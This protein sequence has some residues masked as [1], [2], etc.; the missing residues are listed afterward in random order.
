MEPLQGIALSA[1]LSISFTISLITTWRCD[2]K[3]NSHRKVLPIGTLW[4][5]STLIYITIPCITKNLFNISTF[6]HHETIHILTRTHETQAISLSIMAFSAGYYLLHKLAGQ[7]QHNTSRYNQRGDTL[8]LKSNY[9]AKGSL[10]NIAYTSGLIAISV[11]ILKILAGVQSRF[12]HSSLQINMLRIIDFIPLGILS[13]SIY[14][15]TATS[16]IATAGD[17]N[18]RSA[19]QIA[20]LGFLILI[21]EIKSGSRS[22]LL[23]NMLSAVLGLAYSGQW[24][25]KSTIKL[26]AISIATI[27]ILVPSAE[28]LRI[29]R[30][31]TDFFKDN[32][33]RTIERIKTGA[34]ETLQS[35]PANWV[36]HNRRD[37]LS[38]VV[39]PT[40]SDC[41]NAMVENKFSTLPQA[42][43]LPETRLADCIQHDEQM[44]K[45]KYLP[46]P[47]EIAKGIITG[48][49]KIL[50]DPDERMNKLANKASA[51]PGSVSKGEKLTLIADSY[52][53]FGYMGIAG[54]FVTLGFIYGTIK[55]ILIKWSSDGLMEKRIT[56]AL[57]PI[58]LMA[59]TFSY[60]LLT[61]GWAAL[62]FL[63]KLIISCLLIAFMAKN[64]TH[65]QT[66]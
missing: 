48:N 3:L 24:K 59:G 39:F 64:R 18:R 26:I 22:Y 23:S 43:L 51:R 65:R 53:R 1:V 20:I 35:N 9:R 19:M 49:T 32:P 36:V 63:P 50:F 56:I 58:V 62:V 34:L 27:A 54:V 5:I 28:A 55:K 21:L 40:S 16:L 37:S 2:R 41:R 4:M 7:H 29:A 13:T 45:T 47:Q 46:S 61:Q 52:Q 25:P 11:Q 17:K 66:C 31:S 10:A 6:V 42:Q 8:R 44:I 15:F 30:S 57:S 12:H 14:F 33:I 38:E 60:P